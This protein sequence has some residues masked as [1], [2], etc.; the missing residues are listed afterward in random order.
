MGAIASGRIGVLDEQMVGALAVPCR[1]VDAV[2]AR[3][4]RELEQSERALRG[5]KRPA[6]LRGRP[7]VLVDEGMIVSS[8]VIAAVE[9]VSR[10]GPSS[11][12][13]GVPVASL[14]AY[15]ELMGHVGAVACVYAVPS[16]CSITQCYDELPWP[17]DGEVRE[18]LEKATKAC[19]FWR[20]FVRSPT[21]ATD[22]APVATFRRP[23]TASA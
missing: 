8:T 16:L 2:I 14:E 4:A 7:I 13:V 11:I 12:T 15:E 1:V 9:A 18:L 3:E 19:G 17:T 23:R 20:S 10:T 5:S 22:S 6:R 21:R